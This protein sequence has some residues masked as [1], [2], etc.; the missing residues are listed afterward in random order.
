MPDEVN[1]KYP[2]V[3]VISYNCFSMEGSNGRTLAN[4]FFKWDNNNIA[5]LYICREIPNHRVCHKYFRV[6]DIDLINSCK[7]KHTSGPVK[8][9]DNNTYS[10][11]ENHLFN[12]LNK[13]KVKNKVKMKLLRTYLWNTGVW[14]SAAYHSWLM[15]FKPEILFVMAGSNFFIDK[16]ALDISKNLNLPIIVYNCENYQFK[17]YRCHG[18]WGRLFQSSLI[19]SYHRLMKKT[20][21]VI[22]LNE[23]LQQLYQTKY[24][25]KSSVIYNS[26]SITGSNDKNQE[27]KAL[28][29]SYLGNIEARYH[30]LIAI[31]ETIH[32]IDPSLLLHIYGC[33]NNRNTRELINA[34]GSIHYHGVISYTQV[35]KIIKQS[36]LLVHCESFDKAEI[37]DKVFAF[38]TKIPDL[39]ASGNCLF[40]FAPKSNA[41]AKYLMENNAACVVTDIHDLKR[42]LE[43]I[44]EDSEARSYYAQRAL[45]LARLNH[46]ITDNSNKIYQIIKK[47][48]YEWNHKNERAK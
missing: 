22:Y 17:D 46:N 38:S 41:A 5:Q 2:R 36:D 13:K 44:I 20:C 30:S 23:Q 37:I 12:Q 48:L 9:Y 11:K 45:K 40:V 26:S 16:I 33:I 21:H 47:S 19:N 35:I 25:N 18:I 10:Q 29:I 39:L 32:S 42:E 1:K 28:M 43:L 27:K 4:L 24:T 6:T 15:A 3:L 7:G 34:C 31:A 8:L 14:K